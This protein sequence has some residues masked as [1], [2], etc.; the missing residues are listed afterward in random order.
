MST[1]H[2][3]HFRRY[4][5][6]DHILSVIV[7]HI[8]NLTILSLWTTQVRV[9]ILFTFISKFLRTYFKKSMSYVMNSELLSFSCNTWFRRLI[10]VATCFNAPCWKFRNRYFKI[11]M[12]AFAIFLSDFPFSISK[13]DKYEVWDIYFPVHFTINHETESETY[14]F[15][16][17]IPD[18]L[19][20][21][22]N[23]KIH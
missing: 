11:I 6:C 14:I 22:F 16:H 1:S 15:R 9:N 5:S 19:Y 2:K 7:V 17:P 20:S 18:I 13:H 4:I 21:C 8:N 23:M 10:S 12:F 3:I